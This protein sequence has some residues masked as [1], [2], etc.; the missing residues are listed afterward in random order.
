MFKL[1]CR[2]H[3]QASIAQYIIVF[4]LAIGAIV[5]MTTFVQRILQA[6]IRDAKIYMIDN[7]KTYG[8][9]QGSMAYEYEPYYANIATTLDRN[10]NEELR[11]LGGGAAGIHRKNI[12]TQT[13]SDTA[14]EQAPPQ[15]AI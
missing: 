10:K 9:V 7:V 1:L 12:S 8:N 11:L 3:G 14:S 13:M 2:K 15:N 5:A 4:F 6:R